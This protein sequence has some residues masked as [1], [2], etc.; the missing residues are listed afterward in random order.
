MWAVALY[1]DAFG[2]VLDY[3]PWLQRTDVQDA[4]DCPESCASSVGCCARSS[5]LEAF[6]DA[7]GGL[8]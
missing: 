2:N 4:I 7:V 8:G 5:A 6:N 1:C 3:Q